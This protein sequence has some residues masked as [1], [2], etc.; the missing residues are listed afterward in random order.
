MSEQNAEAGQKNFGIQ[1]IYV[2]DMSFETPNS[3]AIFTKDWTPEINL[4]L[5][6]QANK[7]A[8]GVHEVVLSLTV[9]AKLGDSTAYLAEV[10]QAGIFAMQGFV[11]EELAPMLGAFCPGT[12][13]PY[14]RETVT[15]LVARGG[16]P[17]L[18]LAPI[19]FDALY[20]QQIQKVQAQVVDPNQAQH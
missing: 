8:D 14:A 12:L 2:K 3:P 7:L 17:Q 11:Q 9:T 10:Q 6:T 5:N 4:E 1:K 13:Y 19:N 20:A 18:V 16:F 15:D